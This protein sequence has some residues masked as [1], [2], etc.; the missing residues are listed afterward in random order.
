MPIP[1]QVIIPQKTIFCF[2]DCLGMPTSGHAQN[3]RGKG[4]KIFLRMG[5]SGLKREYN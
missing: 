1:Q 5:R 2:L 4:G 3:L